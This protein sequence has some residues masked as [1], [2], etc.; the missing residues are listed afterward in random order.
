MLDEDHRM[1]M[2]DKGIERLQQFVD[3]MKMKSCCGLIKYKENMPGTFFLAQE[4]SQ[5][6]S[7]ALT[8]R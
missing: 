5:L 1:T 4:V 6:H 3:I 8:S 2:I 7:L